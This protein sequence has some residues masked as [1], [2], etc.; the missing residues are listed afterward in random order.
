MEH[1]I[2]EKIK[3]MNHCI[4][5]TIREGHLMAEVKVTL[6]PD[7]GAWGPYFS[8][9]DALK[10]ERVRLALRAGDKVAAA[11]DAM[12]FEVAMVSAE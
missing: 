1:C 10:L 2:D 6:I 8:A 4:T 9:E 12:V 7:D 11:K 3:A 5:K